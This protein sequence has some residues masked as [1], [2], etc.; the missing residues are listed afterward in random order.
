MLST[1]RRGECFEVTF[2]TWRNRDCRRQA[3]IKFRPPNDDLTYWHGFV[4]AILYKDEPS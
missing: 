2:P 4:H 3:E 1:C